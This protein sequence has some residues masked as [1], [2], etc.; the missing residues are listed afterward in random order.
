[1]LSATYD[2]SKRAASQ[3]APFLRSPNIPRLTYTGL[4]SY[5]IADKGE[6]GFSFNGQTSTPGGDGRSYP[7]SVLFGAFAK[8]RPIENIEVGISA[9]NLFNSFALQGAG[10]VV[11]ATHI[12]AGGAQ[13]RSVRGSIKFSF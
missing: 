7:G 13:G 2:N 5:D 1:V 12:N 3:V 10:G 11:D 6:I 9:Y 4:V 8:I